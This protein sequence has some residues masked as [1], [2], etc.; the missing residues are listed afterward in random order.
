MYLY[1]LKGKLVLSRGRGDELKRQETNEHSM[2]FK[3]TTMVTLGIF[4]GIP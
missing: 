1:E 4:H 2:L 3:V